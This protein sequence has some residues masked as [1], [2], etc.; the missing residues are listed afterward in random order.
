MRFYVVLWDCMVSRVRSTVEYVLY[1]DVVV[2]VLF[3]LEFV[4]WH[5]ATLDQLK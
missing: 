2:S 3:I 1:Y 4:Y 5:S